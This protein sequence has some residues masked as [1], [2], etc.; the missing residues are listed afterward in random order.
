VNIFARLAQHLAGDPGARGV[1]DRVVTVQQLEVV[2]PDDF[3]HP[4]RESEIVRRKLE[5]GITADIDLVE[6]NAGQERWKAEWLSVRDEVDFVPALRQRDAELGRYGAGPTVRRVTGN[7]YVHS[8]PSH[9]S[10]TTARA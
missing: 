9:H 10:R 7:A 2:A 4:H 8:A 6:K 3:V 5:E 1:R